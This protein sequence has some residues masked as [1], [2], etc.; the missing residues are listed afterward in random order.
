MNESIDTCFSFDTTGSMYPCLTQ[1]R[2]IVGQTVERLLRD[3]PDLRIAI[4]AHGDY[5]DEGKTYVTKIFDFSKNVDNI[6]R[7]INTVGPTHG[8]DAP[9]CYELVL[10]EART[11]LSWESGRSKV[12]VMIGDDVP[13]G[14]NY[15]MNTKN[16]DWR[17]ELGL[18]LEAGINVHGIHAM[19]GTRRHSKPF[20]E[21]IASKTGGFYLTLDQFYAVN[22]LIMGICYKQ[23]SEESFMN[24]ANEVQSKG[25]MTRNLKMS[26]SVMSEGVKA[27]FETFDKTYS[28]EEDGLTPVPSGRF[29]VIPVGVREPTIQDFIKDQG[30]DYE[31]GRGFYEL[32]S[33]RTSSGKLKRYKVQQYKEIILMDKDS[34]DLFTGSEAREVLGLL[35]QIEIVGKDR[36]ETENIGAKSLGRYKI[37]IQSTSYTRK[38]VPGSSLLYEVS[39]WDRIAA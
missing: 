21:E 23:E 24:F 20:Y 8:G 16:I 13:H 9:E 32:V 26:F 14:Q 6:I 39:D 10:H 18:L 27:T 1:V 36:G 30:I 12:L 34:G 17:N 3:I 38:L 33:H 4:I 37:F 5:C 28:Y 7:F 15:S 2:R 19:P 29:M 25:R 35:P 11:K 22:D 31:K